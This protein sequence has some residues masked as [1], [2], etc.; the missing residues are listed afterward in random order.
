MPK[1]TKTTVVM[2]LMLLALSLSSAAAGPSRQEGKYSVAGIDDERAVE[3]FLADLQEAVAQDDRARVASMLSYPL[4]LHSGKRR[5][6]L[7]RKSD[8]LKKYGVV[9]NR[10]VKDALAKQKASELFANWQ[11]VMIGDGAI[12]FGEVGGAGQLKVVAV[13]N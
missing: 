3:K 9:F 13:N 11:G 5:T 12:W 1:F 7:R 8:L 6:V 4:T 2:L 10:K